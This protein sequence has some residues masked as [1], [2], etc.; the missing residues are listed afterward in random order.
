MNSKKKKLA[1]QTKV[2]SDEA[3][4]LLKM[5]NQI[6]EAEKL[7]MIDKENATEAAI[8]LNEQ[9][10]AEMEKAIDLQ[11]EFIAEIDSK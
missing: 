4:R 5:S 10:I 3:T 7:G 2:H 1:R 9:A 8:N 11:K 6:H